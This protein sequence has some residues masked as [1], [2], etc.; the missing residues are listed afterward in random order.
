MNK[1]VNTFLLAGDKFMSEM[2]LKKTVFTYSACGLFTKNRER[3][4]KFKQKIDTNYIYKNELSKA[5]LQYS[6]DYGD[7]KDL[8]RRTA[9]EKI[10]RD[11]AFNI[12]KNPKY[13]GYQRGLASILYKCFDKK[14]AGSGVNMHANNERSLDLA[15]ELHK[16]IIRKLKKRTVYTGFKDNIW[17]ADLADKQLI[18]KFNKA[19]LDFYSALLIF[20]VNMLG[21]FLSKIKKVLQLLILFRKF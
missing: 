12:A 3:F 6:M 17:G 16:S 2:H 19:S 14:S 21:L 11:K 13:D 9:S 7:F 15:E 8:T 4:Q 5:C 18:S 1:I 20:L 10:L